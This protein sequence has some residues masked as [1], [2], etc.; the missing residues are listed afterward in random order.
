[1]ENKFEYRLFKFFGV[2]IW[3]EKS[4]KGNTKIYRECSYETPNKKLVKYRVN[5]D[6]E[7][8]PKYSPDEISSCFV[9]HEII[10]NE[11]AKKVFKKDV[12]SQYQKAKDKLVKKKYGNIKA[13]TK[14]D[15]CT[16]KEIIHDRDSAKY[17]N[18]FWI[19]DGISYVGKNEGEVGEY[20]DRFILWKNQEKMDEYYKLLKE[21]EIETIKM[22]YVLAN[23]KK[24][25]ITYPSISNFN[26]S[27]I[28]LINYL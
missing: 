3:T 23:T 22:E 28:E 6:F 11:K 14:L 7:T 10:L 24:E 17:E 13:A 18:G 12:D 19:I 27:D 9:K 4:K 5:S 20:N 15:N 1:M 25:Y 16:P 26:V 2:K 8:I 21:R